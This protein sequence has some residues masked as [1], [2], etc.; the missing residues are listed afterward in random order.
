MSFPIPLGLLASLR[1]I[2]ALSSNPAAIK[3]PID[4]RLD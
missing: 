2:A 3:L 1:E 4:T